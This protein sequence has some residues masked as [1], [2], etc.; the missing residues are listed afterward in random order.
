MRRTHSVCHSPPFLFPPWHKFRARALLLKEAA[1]RRRK[2]RERERERGGSEIV[3]FAHSS[4]PSVAFS[5]FG[6]F[7]FPNQISMRP[8]FLPCDVVT[9]MSGV[10]LRLAPRGEAISYEGTA[11]K[12]VRLRSNPSLTSAYV[13]TKRAPRS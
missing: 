8:P 1:G 13:G 12:K 2:D 6:V 4:V 7:S 11:F 5:G 3:T 10:C 9:V